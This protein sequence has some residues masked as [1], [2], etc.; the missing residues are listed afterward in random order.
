MGAMDNR[1][2]D[3]VRFFETETVVLVQMVMTVMVLMVVSA[4]VSQ[5]CF[6]QTFLLF[7]TILWE[8]HAYVTDYL[9]VF[10][11]PSGVPR[12]GYAVNILGTL[13]L[14]NHFL[15]SRRSFHGSFHN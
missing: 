15:F 8:H 3:V 11:P 2:Y 14:T 7:A 5:R 1:D 9:N 13:P 12:V 6:F 10:P 4:W